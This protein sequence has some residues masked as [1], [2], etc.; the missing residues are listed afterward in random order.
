MI[1][2]GN[3]KWAKQ[4]LLPPGTYEYCLVVDGKW[5][6]DPN[7]QTTVPNPFGGR[8]S[9]LDVADGPVTGSTRNSAEQRC[10]RARGG[11]SS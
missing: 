8:N 1:A 7:A 5:I 2:M 9:V 3:G 4:L 11:P 10:R 6:T